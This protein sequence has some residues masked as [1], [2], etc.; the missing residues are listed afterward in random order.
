[1]NDADLDKDKSVLGMTESK[2]PKI[3]KSPSDKPI[4]DVSSKTPKL[5]K[6]PSDDFLR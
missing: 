3:S 5:S 2:T 6:T 1:M 4:S